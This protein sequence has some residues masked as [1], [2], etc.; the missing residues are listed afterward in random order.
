MPASDGYAA[1]RWGLTVRQRDLGAIEAFVDAR[2]CD[3]NHFK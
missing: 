3:Y 2:D 1:S